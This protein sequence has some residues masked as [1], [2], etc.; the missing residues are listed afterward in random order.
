M[1][2]SPLRPAFSQSPVFRDRLLLSVPRAQATRLRDRLRC[3]GL[4]IV[5]CYDEQ[6]S[7]ALEFPRGLSQDA[8]L[9]LLSRIDTAAAKPSQVSAA[10]RADVAPALSA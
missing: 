1:A 6:Q 5:I 2:P 8:V 7:A 3:V 4:E 10:S 9:G